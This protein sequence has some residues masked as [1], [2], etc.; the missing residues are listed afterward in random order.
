MILGQ[1]SGPYAGV[2]IQAEFISFEGRTCSVAIPPISASRANTTQAFTSPGVLAN[3][4]A[5]FQGGTHEA[6]GGSVFIARYNLTGGTWDTSGS[7]YKPKY[8]SVY[9]INT[10]DYVTV[11]ENDHLLLLLVLLSK[12]LQLDYLSDKQSDQ[13]SPKADKSKDMTFKIGYYVQNPFFN[14]V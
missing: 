3:G 10:M 5:I 9:Q 12:R 1:T 14:P 7:G 6:G 8:H 11:G 2:S 4:M 13:S